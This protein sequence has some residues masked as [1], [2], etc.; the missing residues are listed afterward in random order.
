M[1]HRIVAY[2]YLNLDIEKPKQVVDHQDIDKSN[3]FV[4][5]LRIV[6][7]QNT[8]NIHAKGYCYEK[9]E[10]NGKHELC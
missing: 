5:N 2:A 1:V 7:Q 9:K 10:I 3:N 6:T 4:S 8:F